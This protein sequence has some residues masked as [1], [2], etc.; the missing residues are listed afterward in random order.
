MTVFTCQPYSNSEKS[1]WNVSVFRHTSFHIIM[2]YWNKSST[3][4]A[5]RLSI[6][7]ISGDYLQEN[8]HT[9]CS[10][11][12]EQ[13]YYLH[14]RIT[15]ISSSRSRLLI[16]SL[17]STTRRL[18]SD[19]RRDAYKDTYAFRSLAFFSSCSHDTVPLH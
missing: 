1:Q 10:K 9:G 17:S 13:T 8:L 3:N 14:C 19:F 4:T 5:T 6:I 7:I 12:K 18:M 16:S 15:S 2:N 11:S